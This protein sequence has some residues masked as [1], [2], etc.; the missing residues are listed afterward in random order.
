MKAMKSMHKILTIA[1][2]E[3]AALVATR[4][5]LVGLCL[6][7][8]LLLGGLVAP[9]LTDARLQERCRIAVVDHTGR[10]TTSLQEELRR[11]RA[12]QDFSSGL[13]RLQ[14]LSG[15]QA[16]NP[17][18]MPEFEL[19][20]ISTAEFT[21]E[22]RLTLSERIRS[23]ELYGFL[24]IPVDL[25]SADAATTTAG[26]LWVSEVTVLARNRRYLSE[27]LSEVVRM[28]RLSARLDADD[29]K[30]VQQH[31]AIHDSLEIRSPYYRDATGQIVAG[32]RKSTFSSVVVPMVLLLVMFLVIMMSAQPMLESV[33]EEK[34]QRISEVLLGSASA[35]QLMIGKL[36]G[37]VAGSLTIFA[38][39]SAGCLTL[40]VVAGVPAIL[41][42]SVLP[43]FLLYQVL[44]VLQFSALFMSIAAAVSQMREAQCLLMPVWGVIMLPMFLLLSILEDPNSTIATAISF[45]PPSAPMVMTMRLTSGTPIPPLQIVCSLLVLLAGTVCSIIAAARIYRGGLLLQGRAART[46]DVLNWLWNTDDTQ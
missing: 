15:D 13:S 43:W 24:E 25:L 34:T 42:T 39:Y 27:A 4:A 35:R 44:A 17:E 6:T 30:F 45:F 23:G 46:G 9:G 33:L 40:G 32:N 14:H 22:E 1:R 3:Y 18:Q 31:S 41:S 36:L 5:F 28:A 19:E 20:E 37:N 16:D 21:D 11:P 12:V 7:P 10:L 38:L 8:L 29:L 26:P 2:R